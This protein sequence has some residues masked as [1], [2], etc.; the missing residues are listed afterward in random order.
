MNSPVT[1]ADFYRYC[2][3][4]G[5]M[6][7]MALIATVRMWCIP[8]E[9]P[10]LDA[11]VA[12]WTSASA[13]MTQLAQTE[14]GLADTAAASDFPPELQNRLQEIEIDHLFKAS[15]SAL[16]WSFKLVEIDKLVAP[17]REV[18]LDYVNELRTRIPGNSIHDLVDFC[19][20]PR[21]TPPDLKILQTTQNQLIVTS[22]SLDLRFLGGFRKPLREDDIAVAHTGGQPVEAISLLIG[23]GSSTINVYHVGNRYILNNGFHRIFALRTAGLT[24]VPAVVQ[25][26]AQPQI[27]FPDHIQ[28]LSRGYLIAENRPVLV[29]DF[30][31]DTLTI[32]LRISPRRKAVKVAWGAEDSVIPV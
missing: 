1:S 2:V 28:G 12:A 30:F 5:A 9:L 29:K 18:N 20:A 17:Q 26:V 15:F 22:K 23:F 32:E 31:D 8:A 19:L 3:L 14:S 16:P 6:Q 21:P 11:I 24:H 10:R 25:H 7:R 4:M 13:R 27:E